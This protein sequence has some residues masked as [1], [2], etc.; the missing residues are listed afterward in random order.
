MLRAA[1]LF[2]SFPLAAALWLTVL[3]GSGAQAAQDPAQFMID[4]DRQATAPFLDESLSHEARIE[5]VRRLAERSFDTAKIGKFVLGVHWRRAT[6]EQQAAF[7]E[8]F[9]EV[10]LQRFLPLF[11]K[12]IDHS[13]TVQKVR[14][15]ER[16]PELFFVTSVITQ[17]ANP[18]VT[19]EWR[20]VREGDG[21]RILDVVAEGVSMVLTL[22]NEYASV[23]K[24]DGM[25]GLIAQLRSKVKSGQTANS[26]Q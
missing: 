5:T 15:D 19:V 4:L 18:P 22:R 25:D 23:I 17:G 14:Q 16:K 9:G 20:L 24:T 1:S 6:P 11:T 12:Y 13:F 3:T 7:L 8:V 21:Y 26:A 10:N 2:S